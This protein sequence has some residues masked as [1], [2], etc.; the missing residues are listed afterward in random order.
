VHGTQPLRLRFDSYE[1]DE[2]NV[3]L[4]CNRQPVELTPKAFAVLCALIRNHGD[5]VTKD[6][7]LDAA[8]GHHFVSESVLKTTIS[9]LRSALSDNARNPR[10]I[11]TV[12][13][14]GYRFIGGI[15]TAP[16]P[17]ALPAREDPDVAPIIG[18]EAASERLRQYWERTLA[19]DGQLVW[20]VGDAGVG[21]TTL[22]EAFL[23]E[24][25]AGTAVVGRCVEHFGASEPYLPLLEAIKELCRREPDIVAVMRSVAPTWLVQMPWLTGEEERAA[26]HRELAGAHPDRMVRELGEMIERY[27]ARAP[28]L[29]VL[30]DLHWSDLG[31]LRMM[32]HFA[33][34][35]RHFRFMWIAS[36][37]LTQVF[38]EEHPLKELRQELRLH[39]LCEEIQLEPFSE[40]EVDAYLNLRLPDRAYPEDFIRRLHTH[41]DGLPL[42]VANVT[43]TLVARLSAGRLNSEE[44][45]EAAANLP[46]PES[47]AGI[48]ERQIERLPPDRRLLLEAASVCGMDFRAATLSS[49]LE[50][51][52]AWIRE[53]CDDMLR[54]RLWLQD[55]AF[56]DLPDGSFDTRYRFQHALYLHAFYQRIPASRRVQYHRQV[57]AWLRQLRA[58]GDIVAPAELASHLEYGREMAAAIR[59]YAEGA[60]AAL[61]YFAPKDAEELAG[62][63]LRLVEHVG[64]EVQRNELELSLMAHRGVAASL[65]YGVASDEA[66][67]AF[68]RVSELC[69]V[70]PPSPQRAMALNGLGWIHFT[71]GEFD[72]ALELAMRLLD[73]AAAHGDDALFVYGCN[74]RG[75]TLVWKGDVEGASDSM[76]RGLDRCASLDGSLAIESFVIDPE[77]S[78]RSNLTVP[79]ADR[80]LL[81]QA[82]GHVRGALERAA[83]IGQPI[84][85]MLAHWVAAQ[86]HMRLDEPEAVLVHARAI[87]DVVESAMLAHGEGPSLWMRGW[88]EARLGDPR[89][90]YD[91]I[92]KG[93]ACHTRLGM[94]AGC[95]EVLA[96]ATEAL[97]LA[98][99]WSAA[100][101]ELD[102]AFELA[103]RIGERLSIPRLLLHRA[104]IAVAADDA[105]AAEAAIR[106]AI[107]EARAL[108]LRDPELRANVA[109]HDLGRATAADVAELLR[110]CQT[111]D[112]GHHT[113]LYQRAA[114]YAGLRLTA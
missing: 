9:Q 26:L 2:G 56:V 34:Q 91:L 19:G 12:S 84:A 114:A 74:L 38:A 101:A 58:A 25:P 44:W 11:E 37:R 1:L 96:Y 51:D 31:T 57:A 8:W 97:I 10:Y 49:M 86:V 110:L 95:T 78:M 71:R 17:A 66:R 7:L 73:I 69:D 113:Q 82:M 54:R 72:D 41:T 39:R 13:R 28:L 59:A 94:Y 48:L 107:A 83:A 85:N 108:G 106:E 24:L 6:A 102:E 36:F 4:T 109:L 35:P 27:T 3:R 29:L 93:Y 98:G 14:F 47:L 53:Q 60:G 105:G 92:R 15:D 55:V 70:L 112:E 5:L 80:G 90:G 65:L 50:R 61:R 33:R 64:D 68:E 43:E 104:R 87:A 79:L 89:G 32:E 103:A 22:I 99:D 77:V 111:L 23:R 62:R 18:R 63:A 40:H 100:A 76:Q 75:V 42:F 30:E 52:A 45:L 20:I 21:K 81:D 67:N 46:L 88:A 16:S